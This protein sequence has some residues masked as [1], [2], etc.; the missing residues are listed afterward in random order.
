MT[1]SADPLQFPTEDHTIETARVETFAGERVV[2]YRSYKHLPYVA[3]PVDRDYQSLDV[4]VPVAIEGVAVDATDAPVILANSIGGFL[5]VNNL[6]GDMQGPRGEGS[7]SWRH[8][9]LALVAGY[10]VVC[11]GVRGRDNQSPDG[12]YYGKAPAA[13]VDLKA[14]VRY[15]RHNRGVIPG[16]VD[17]IVSTGCSAGGGLSALLGASGNSRLY[18]P[19]LEEIG[20]A[21]ADDSIYAAGCYSPIMDLEHADM[22]YEWMSGQTPNNESGR[23]VD[24]ELSAQLKAL[25]VD[26]QAS[27]GLQGR[28][29]FGLLTAE[30][31]DRYLMRYYL[32]PSATKY[33][34]TLTDI[35]RDAY[36]ANHRW[37]AWDGEC[38]EFSF[39]DYAL[40]AG[41]F[42]M[43]PAFD[44][45]DLKLAETSLFGDKTTEARHFTEFSLRKAA[46]DPSAEL[47]GEV[48][49]LTD[50][51]NPMSFVTRDNT[52]CA[53]HWWLR[54]GT[55]E[56]GI[57]MTAIT[58]LA[59]S[60]ENRGKHVNTWFF[61]D[62][63]H[64]I[65]QDAEGF[66]A[67][68]GEITGSRGS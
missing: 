43:I 53:Q 46:D 61:W 45:L 33:L 47:D 12:V 40:H 54:R 39:A 32:L 65:D 3:R 68:V 55:G 49:A 34:A 19:Y 10:V 29:G 20:A 50:L 36:L 2:T 22:A 17:H 31:Y 15:L 11:P 57:S 8:A 25:F 60:L 62:A 4:M 9:E 18:D 6:R 63:M 59:V 56:S 16:N 1:I 58:N 37:V 14:A 7:V 28:D 26:Y 67:W 5:S 13:I 38:A 66:I 51:M 64:C 30:N 41:R 24:Q 52:D 35:E 42:K 27:L 44:D 21:D 23:L 48:R